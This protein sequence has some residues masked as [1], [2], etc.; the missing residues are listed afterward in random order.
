MIAIGT[1]DNF[2]IVVSGVKGSL[3]P[4]VGLIYETLTTRSLGRGRD[5]LWLARGSGRLSGRFFLGQVS[6][7]QRGA[8]ARR[9]AGDAGRRDLLVR[10]AEEEQPDVHRLLPAR[11]QGGE[12][13]RTRGQIHLRCSGKPRTAEH[14]RRSHRCCRSIGGKAPTAKASK[15]D[16]SATTLEKPLGSGP[17]RIKEFVAGRSVVLERVK[18]YWGKDLPVQI[19]PNNFDELRFEFFR[20]NWSRWRPSRPIRP[21]GSRRIRRSNGRPPTIFRRYAKS[22]SSRRSSRSAASGRMQGFAFNLRRELFKDVRLRRAFNYAFDFEEMNKQLF[23][24][25]V[26]ARSTAISTAP[27]LATGLPEGEE[28]RN[29]R[30]RARQ[31]AGRGVHDAL[32]Q[33]GRRQSGGGAQQSARGHA[34]A[35]GGRLRDQG[36]QAGRSPGKPVS[37]EFLTAGSGDGAPDAVLQAV[38]GAPRHHGRRSA[39]STTRNTK[40]AC[41]TSIST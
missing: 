38:A 23:Y 30:N 18:D 15:R 20:D 39:P 21:T 16:I 1:F 14:R 40:I 10:R 7:A 27:D 31:G 6:A 35:E 2:N 22:A 32:Q 12:D 9:Q 4:A 17:Y 13:R 8:L 3:A 28:L 34:A 33:S 19:G 36:P 29:S 5:V 25:A 41:A 26:Q 24:G 37:V 11:R